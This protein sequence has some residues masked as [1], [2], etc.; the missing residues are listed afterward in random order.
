MRLFIF[1]GPNGSGKSTVIKNFI[2]NYGLNDYE[3]INPD[4]Y[5][6]RFFYD[7]KGEKERYQKAFKFAE[8][9]REETLK[10]RKNIIV[11]TVNSTTDKF[12][13]YKRCKDSGY[14]ITVVFI[15]TKSA[16]IN[17]ARVKKRVE[18][19]GHDVSLEKIVSRYYKSL[20][21]LF[22][23]SLY[24]DVLY[25]LDNSEDQVGA[26]L[27]IYQDK[28]GLNTVLPLPSWVN[29]YFIERLKRF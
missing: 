25:I 14:E 6:T 26:K 17:C 20:D 16:E 9:K 4:I 1:A 8:Y 15:A 5:A 27:C 18:Q 2:D 11:E 10:N 3:Y 24:S 13:F 23:L 21:N 28:N 29:T 22:D 12:E 7:I 19:G